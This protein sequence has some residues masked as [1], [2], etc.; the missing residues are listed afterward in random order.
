M[1]FVLYIRK[2]AKI[3]EQIYLAEDQ[4]TKIIKHTY[5]KR[6]LKIIGTDCQREGDLTYSKIRRR[7]EYNKLAKYIDKDPS[8]L[9]LINGKVYVLKVA[10]GNI[11]NKYYDQGYRGIVSTIERIIQRFYILNL[12]K[13]LKLLIVKYNTCKRTKYKQ[14]KLTRDPQRIDIP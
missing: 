5:Y 14:Y 4:T 13:K 1:I 11:L 3:Q 2:E 7:Y 8:G 12:R 9:Y 10:E 6:S